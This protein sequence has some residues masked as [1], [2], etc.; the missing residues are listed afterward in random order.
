[1][2]FDEPTDGRGR[3]GRIRRSK[4]IGAALALLLVVS[5][6]TEA[7]PQAALYVNGEAVS[8]EELALTGGD[9]EAIRMKVLQQ[10][11]AEEGLWEEF[12]YETFQAQLEAENEARAEALA[13][14]GTV[15]GPREYSPRQYYAIR[16]GE[17]ERALR[18]REEAQTTQAQLEEW[19]EA[20]R[21]DFRVFGAVTAEVTVY[22]GRT[23]M[24]RQEVTLEPA[25]QRILSE[26][27]E[28]LVQVLHTLQVG[29][30]QTW[31]DGQGLE[32]TAVCTARAEDSFAPLE[33]VRGAASQQYAAQRVS[34][35]LARRTA[36]SAVEDLRGE[37][38]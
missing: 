26:E 35:E 5:G 23:L 38:P 21:E 4:V 20:H 10:W 24:S 11:A 34:E 7:P 2:Q 6:C 36:E 25:N 13:A 12:S 1:M 30:S 15:Y 8:A 37:T 17:L 16:M 32:W 3:G 14:G 31:T 33:E 9:E 18:G 27:N 28:T 19:Y 22:S 29:E